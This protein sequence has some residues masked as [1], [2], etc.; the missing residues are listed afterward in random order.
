MPASTVIPVLHYPDVPAAAAWL[1]QAFGF[2]ERLR[3]GE[4]RIQ[5]SYGAGDVVVTG[6]AGPDGGAARSHS[7]M[8]RVLDVDDHHRQASSAG[9]E[10]VEPPE[11]FPYGERQ[12]SVRDPGGHIWTFSG[13]VEDADPAEWG[14]QLVGG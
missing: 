12:Y 5:L 14:G 3:I 1:V 2:R 11:T 8:V 10:M 7:V 4:H 9:A 6:P 13:T